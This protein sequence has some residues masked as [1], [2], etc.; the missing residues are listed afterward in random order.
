MVDFKPSAREIWFSRIGSQELALKII[1]DVC[2]GFYVVAALM[3]LL[4]A[5]LSAGAWIDAI[6]YALLA[7]WLRLRKSRVAASLL[8]ILSTVTLV[9]TVGNVLGHWEQGGS[10]LF[11]AMIVFASSIRAVQATLAL[12]HLRTDVSAASTAD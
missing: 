1:R 8:L 5:V 6:A 4:A 7:T 2:N 11:L 12:H 3:A 9:V 10:N